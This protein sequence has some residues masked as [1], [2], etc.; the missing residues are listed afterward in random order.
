M[1]TVR[2]VSK[3]PLLSLNRTNQHARAKEQKRDWLFKGPKESEPLLIPIFQTLL[4]E[5]AGEVPPAAVVL[6]FPFECLG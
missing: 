3:L 6:S 5:L 1:L 4:L 2:I